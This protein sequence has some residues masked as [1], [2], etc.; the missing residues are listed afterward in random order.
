MTLKEGVCIAQYRHKINKYFHICNLFKVT[1]SLLNTTHVCIIV[2]R[3]KYC[4]CCI[5]DGLLLGFGILMSSIIRS[6][7]FFTANGS[8][9]A[10]IHIINLLNPYENN[11]VKKACEPSVCSGSIYVVIFPIKTSYITPFL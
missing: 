4:K 9:T 3:H 8:Q 2:K 11:W 5:Q 10:Y 7:L 6:H 1:W